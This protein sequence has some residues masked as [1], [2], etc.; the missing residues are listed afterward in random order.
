MY[1]GIGLRIAR[2]DGHNNQPG[3]IAQGVEAY[4]AGWIVTLAGQRLDGL[5]LL[6]L[7][8]FQAGQRKQRLHP[9]GLEIGF[10]G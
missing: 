1:I 2:Q 3:S 6:C 7:A 5:R 10:C 4:P 8:L 9:L